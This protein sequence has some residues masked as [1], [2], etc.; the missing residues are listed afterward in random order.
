MDTRAQ[1][2]RL[3]L[4]L[5][6]TPPAHREPVPTLFVPTKLAR[7]PLRPGA[8]ARPRLLDRLADIGHAPLTL[9]SAAAG[10]GKT[11]LLTAWAT[12]HRG[13]IA[14]VGL[15][16]EDNDPARFWRY[17]ASALETE[18]AGVAADIHTMMQAP[19]PPP[20][21]AL[22]A[23]LVEVCSALPPGTVLVLDDYH[24]I[25]AP[26]IHDALAALLARLPAAMH[27]ILAT[28]TDPPLPLA[29]LRARGQLLELRAADLRFTND[30]AA[31]FLRDAMGL[32]LPVEA[33]AALE[34]RTEGWAAGLQLAA[35]A[36]RGRADP[37]DFITAF[38]G[39]HRFV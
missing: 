5:G 6:N 9:V 35:L 12:T 23:T 38:S 15:D 32:D 10:F 17:I 25:T 29:R 31:A 3:T 13:P 14:W 24:L 34:T 39:N 26:P 1:D 19:Q 30:E 18:Q 20:I 22:V 28:R 21:A 27:I 33:I 11:T 36:V 16:P 2:E 37:A 4:T 8:I 7:P